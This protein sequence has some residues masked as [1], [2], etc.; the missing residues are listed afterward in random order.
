[1]P[2]R[3]KVCLIQRIEVRLKGRFRNAQCTGGAWDEYHNFRLQF[4]ER[5]RRRKTYW[6]REKAN[7]RG[8]KME[9]RERGKERG[10]KEKDKKKKDE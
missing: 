3:A 9:G 7:V 6:E 8:G 10:K 2:S 4:Q 1:M 5:E